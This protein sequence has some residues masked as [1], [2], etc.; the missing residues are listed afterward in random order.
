[1]DAPE[2]SVKKLPEKL[3]K[4]AEEL[5]VECRIDGDR[6]R[7]YHE[8]NKLKT[9]WSFS[10]GEQMRGWNYSGLNGEDEMV[11]MVIWE[12]RFGLGLIDMDPAKST[13]PYKP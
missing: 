13:S 4:A 8:G 6:C 3:A 12:I 5:G 7:F 10:A 2:S 9:E 11:D 1:M